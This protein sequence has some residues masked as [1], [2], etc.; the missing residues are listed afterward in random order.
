MPEL[1]A[2]MDT[3]KCLDVVKLMRNYFDGLYHADSK[4]LADVFHPDAIYINMTKGDYMNYSLGEYL[5]II[6]QRTSPA[7]QGELK[8]DE[9]QSIEFDG[10]EMAFVN[11]KMTMMGREYLDFLTLSFDK[12]GWRVISKIFTYKL[13]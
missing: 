6:E 11:A 10:L 9:I 12:N 5:Q 3:D 13:Q 7:S 8:I 4:L 2:Y 1:G